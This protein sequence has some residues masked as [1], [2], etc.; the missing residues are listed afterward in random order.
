MR[1]PFYFVSICCLMLCSPAYSQW[2][3]AR[4]N[5]PGG[6]C[7]QS[8]SQWQSYES[9]AP[10]NFAPV[11]TVIQSPPVQRVVDRLP[12][13]VIFEGSRSYSNDSAQKYDI[14]GD[15]IVPGS[16]RIISRGTASAP[17]SGK[18]STTAT[19]SELAEIK[20]ELAEIRAGQE[21]IKR[22]LKGPYGKETSSLP[23][24]I[25]EAYAMA[26]LHKTEI[27]LAQR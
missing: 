8:V 1:Y 25:R 2:F 4:S 3:G 24:P 14:E 26:A 22:L 15:P 6:N 11:Q 19:Q 5:C 20:A 13:N 27:Q 18:G 9:Y 7:G 17:T 21:E 23:Q 12:S 16:E 10:Q